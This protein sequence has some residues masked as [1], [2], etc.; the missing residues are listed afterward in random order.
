MQDFEK[1]GAFYLGKEYDLQN[2]QR[3]EDLVLYDSKDLTT[4]GMCVGM[5]GSGKTGLCLGLLEEA[6]IDGIPAI[7][8]DPKGDLGNLMLAFPGLTANEFRPWID[9]GEAR[10]QGMSPDEYAKKTAK[11]WKDGLAEWGQTGERIARYKQAAEVA[12]YTPGGSAGLP[13]TVLRSFSAPGPAVLN[14]PDAY[15]ER[16]S[17]A[18]SGLLALLKIDADPIRSREFIL[19]SNILDVN[20]KAGRDLEIA[21]LIHAIQTPPFDKVGFIDLE[22]F[23]PQK[24]R[25][26][27]AMGLNNLLASPAF[28]SWMQGEPLDI[29]RLLYTP[30][31]RPRLSILSIAHLSETERMFFV[32][33]LLNEVLAWV[34]NQPGANSL[35]AM[36]YMDEVFGFFPPTAN[37]P[38]KQ[39]ML[40]LLKQARAFGL[41]VMLATQNPVDLDYKSLSNMGTWFLG[42]LQTERDKLRVLEGLEGAAADSGSRF[43]RQA[44]EKI[45]AGLGSRVFLM[46]NVHEDQ[47]VIFQTRWALSYL[48]GPMSKPQIEQLMDPKK[49]A[50]AANSPSTAAST[51]A[52]G[53]FGAGDAFGDLAPVVASSAAVAAAPAPEKA[54]APATKPVLPPGIDQAY[55]RMR[56][57]L[58]PGEH[59]TYQ[60]AML[61]SARVHF[62][63]ATYKV[64]D[65]VTFTKL[66]HLDTELDEVDWDEA[67]VLNLDD[68][69]LEE[70]GERDAHYDDL[71]KAISARNV[72]KWESELKSMLYR[73]Q[74][75]S[76]W[77][78][79][80]LKQYSKLQETEGDFRIRLTNAA[81]EKRDLAVEKLRAKFASKWD[82]M[83]GRI[84]K[85]E[86][87]VE[88]ER[89]QYR[90]AQMSTAVSFG[91]TLLGAL[92]GRKMASATN[93]SKAGTSLRG[94]GR[95]AQQHGDIGRAQEDV[96]SLKRELSELDASFKEEVRELE[97]SYAPSELELEELSVKPRKT[98][99]DVEELMLVWL[100]VI[101]DSR[102]RPRQAW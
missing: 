68:I 12:I 69:D 81:R 24:E 29:Q 93:I 67:E 74:R 21:Q 15:R 2:K 61:G 16:V 11:M 95:T 23:F 47:P 22:S 84:R 99:I 49:A 58:G 64:D 25:F 63:R 98:D 39:P 13:I 57:R 35:R 43:D 71:P 28:A 56:E 85:A 91:T 59:L 5:T 101:R 50:A 3:L 86:Q 89:G 14:D 45:L 30:E 80:E 9:E 34:R 53:S 79:A 51:P 73:D 32:T 94:V 26:G 60:A 20:W 46:H 96:E 31:G 97:E 41:G 82:T 17:A 72:K 77:K 27:L 42:R 55:I 102:G 52:A 90:S 18:V 37:P 1:L 36:L 78:C 44:M 70:K 88:K 48:R 40:T 6:A 7:A 54:P 8:I 66:R 10:R 65:W 76:V 33:I 62:V 92:F 19:L 4:H 87:K 100:P 38:S 75:L 83:Q